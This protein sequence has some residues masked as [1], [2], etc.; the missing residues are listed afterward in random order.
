MPIAASIPRLSPAA[1]SP[2]VRLLP[3]RQNAMARYWPWRLLLNTT[4]RLHNDA[5]LLRSGAGHDI[6]QDAPA[7]INRFRDRIVVIARNNDHV[8]GRVDAAD[9]TDMAA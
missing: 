6:G 9:H 5:T 4:Q 1:K 3:P 7:R 2:L 8:A